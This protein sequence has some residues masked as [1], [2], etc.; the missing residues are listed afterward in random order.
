LDSTQNGGKR[1]VPN[2]NSNPLSRERHRQVS[3]STALKNKDFYKHAIEAYQR[4][5]EKTESKEKDKKPTEEANP[6]EDKSGEPTEE[7]KPK[8]HG[9]HEE[10]PKKSWKDRIKELG[11]K[12]R[13]FIEKAPKDV[14]KFLEDEGHRRK[15]VLGIH[16]ALVDAPEKLVKSAIQ[17]V[18]DEVKE[19]KEAG[20][21]VAAVLKGKKMSTHQKKAFK[22]VALHLAISIAAS[23]VIGSGVLGVAGAFAKGTV[24]TIAMKSVSKAL[25]HVSV[26]QEIGH[27]GHGVA[28]FIT[29]LASTGSPLF[30]LYKY[31]SQVKVGAEPNVDEVMGNFMAANVA[32]EL[33]TFG[34]DDDVEASLKAMD[35]EG[36][37]EPP[38][39]EEPSD[40][41][42][43]EEP[44]SGDENIV[45]VN[46]NDVS[47]I[48]FVKNQ[49]GSDKMAND[50]V[51]ELEDALLVGRVSQKFAATEEPNFA[52]RRMAYDRAKE[53]AENKNKEY[54]PPL[55]KAAKAYFDALDKTATE[56]KRTE[57]ASALMTEVDAHIK[58]A[59]AT[60]RVLTR[61]NQVFENAAAD[62][63][64]LA[65]VE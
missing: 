30:L 8:E 31:A 58:A 21:G 65:Q 14:K 3:F 38:D 60:V 18:K 50:L 48:W 62:H 26:L 17:T 53:L 4:W 45:K 41:G 25:G 42:T 13:D 9:G 15:V 6:T 33:E 36:T 51:R 39:E 24:Q 10:G 35:D 16:K 19:Y 27:I 29:H 57:L 32:K 54:H 61:Y 52:V 56:E 64:R 5:I 7:A 22:K 55:V 46:L 12:A 28:E 20:Q 11:S 47:E 44:P 34:S 49:E 23:A 2:P 59:E 1:M 63:N 40:E 37:G 43:T